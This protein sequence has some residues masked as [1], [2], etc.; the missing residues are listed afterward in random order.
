MI[1]CDH[2]RINIIVFLASIGANTEIV[3]HKG[4]TVKQYGRAPIQM[5]LHNALA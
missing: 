2:K 1:A 4:R 5:I 3:D